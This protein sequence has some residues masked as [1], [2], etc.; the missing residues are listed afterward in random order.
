MRGSSTGTVSTGMLWIVRAA[1]GILR[2][3]VSR[4]CEIGAQKQ[5]S[6]V[7]LFFL[8]EEQEVCGGTRH[9]CRP[10]VS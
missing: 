10:A 6:D 5:T 7:R 8:R 3:Q 9:V 4:V 1:A 2:Y